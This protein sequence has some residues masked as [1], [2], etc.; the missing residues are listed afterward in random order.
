MVWLLVA[1]ALVAGGI[2]K[3]VGEAAQIRD[4]SSHTR[5]SADFSTGDFSQW[6]WWGQD[7]PTYGH[8]SVVD[9]ATYGIPRPPLDGERRVGRML[10][11]KRDAKLGRVN[12]KLYKGWSR[13]GRPPA[14]VSGTYSAW[15]FL[16]RRYAVPL[17]TDAN[18][19]QFKEKHGGQSDP[20]WWVQLSTASWAERMRGSR[21]LGKRPRRA[22]QPVAVL[23]HADNRWRRRSTFMPVP[24]GRWFQIRADVRQGDRIDFTIDGRRFDTARQREYPISPFRADSQEWIFG[25]GNYTAAPNTVVYVGRASYVRR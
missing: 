14:D 4:A 8:I 6:S 7:D 19:F 9:P 13:H 22:D 15:Y 24:L 21:W 25:I 10:V 3:R 17:G 2:E 16:R 12:A 5:W 23:N 18:I 11:T 1:C 20:L